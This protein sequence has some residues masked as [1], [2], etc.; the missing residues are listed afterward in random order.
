MKGADDGSLRRVEHPRLVA[1]AILGAV[2]T[3]GVNAISTGRGRKLDEVAG[4]L[5]GFVLEGVS[6]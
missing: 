6:A 4:D 3:V 5:V 1:V 2:T